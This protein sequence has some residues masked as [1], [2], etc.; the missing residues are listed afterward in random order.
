MDLLEFAEGPLGSLVLHPEG[1]KMSHELLDLLQ[2]AGR[3]VAW[4]VRPVFTW[5]FPGIWSPRWLK[6]NRLNLSVVSGDVLAI[7]K[8]ATVLI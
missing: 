2:P 3:G 7:S 6:K 1:A 4:R 8:G 5:V